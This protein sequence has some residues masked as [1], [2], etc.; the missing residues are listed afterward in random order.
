MKPLLDSKA[1]CE[2]LGIKPPTLSR[3][4][5]ANKI[6]YVLLGTGKKKLTVRFREAELEVWLDRRSR[7]ALPKTKHGAIMANEEAPKG[8]RKTEPEKIV[9]GIAKRPPWKLTPVRPF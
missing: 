3:M 2:I 9:R 5:H 8:L 6:P 1:V 7:G 4:V